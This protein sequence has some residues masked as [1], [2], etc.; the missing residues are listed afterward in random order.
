L[1]DRWIDEVGLHFE[2][3]GRK[4]CGENMMKEEENLVFSETSS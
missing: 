3:Q 4:K 2:R 1:P